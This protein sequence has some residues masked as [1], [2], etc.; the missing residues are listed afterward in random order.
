MK[1]LS[2]LASEL[3]G[4][5]FENVLV[6][7]TCGTFKVSTQDTGLYTRKKERLFQKEGFI[8]KSEAHEITLYIV[9]NT[10]HFGLSC[11]KQNKCGLV[12]SNNEE[13]SGACVTMVVM[14]IKTVLEEVLKAR[15]LHSSPMIAEHF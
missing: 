13:G 14:L 9:F 10:E 11:P 5:F 1:L 2:E 8:T 6:S 15:Y 7:H 3:K 12:S 4:A